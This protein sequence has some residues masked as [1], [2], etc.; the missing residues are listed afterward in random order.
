MVPD[1]ITDVTQPGAVLGA[2]ASHIVQM[3]SPELERWKGWT[4]KMFDT[5]IIMDLPWVPE[6]TA[7]LY[8]GL[9]RTKSSVRPGPLLTNRLYRRALGHRRDI[10]CSLLRTPVWTHDSGCCPLL[11]EP[12]Q[13]PKPR[14]LEIGIAT[15]LDSICKNIYVNRPRTILRKVSAKEY[16]LRC[17]L[18][19]LGSHPD[20]TQYLFTFQFD[21][22]ALRH[23]PICVPHLINNPFPISIPPVV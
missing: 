5:W 7:I 22:I 19:L 17:Y 16:C 12:S 9:A 21:W 3:M 14:Q 15:G 6:S 1:Y 10:I 11:P 2:H 23:F 8:V 18:S 13:T 4:T 20:A